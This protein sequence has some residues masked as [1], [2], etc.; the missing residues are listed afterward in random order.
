M[1]GNKEIQP[2]TLSSP[3]LEPIFPAVGGDVGVEVGVAVVQRLGET[4]Q[5]ATETT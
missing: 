1:S 3:S 4:E 5:E 2:I